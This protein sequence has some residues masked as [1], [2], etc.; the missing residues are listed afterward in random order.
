MNPTLMDDSG[1]SRAGSASAGAQ[2]LAEARLYLLNYD[3]A[4]GL[5]PHA[6]I[7]EVFTCSVERER[8][9]LARR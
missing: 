9:C 3:L 1:E 7:V 6:V 2:R 5:R 8:E 4:G